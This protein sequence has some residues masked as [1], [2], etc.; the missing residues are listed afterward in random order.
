MNAWITPGSHPMIVSKTLT[1]NVPPKP[2]FMKTAAGGKIIFNMIVNIDI[3]Y[4]FKCYYF[5]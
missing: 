3:V 1:K 5:S 4:N 2:C